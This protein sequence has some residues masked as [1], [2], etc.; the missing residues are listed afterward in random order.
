V[1]DDRQ[2]REVARRLVDVPGV[3]GVVLGG[4]RARG[5]HA[6]DSDVD[7]GLYYRPPLDV[8]AL[9]RHARELAGP[10]ARL[11]QPGAWGPWVDGGGW[12]RIADTPVDWIY[13][14]IDRVQLSWAAA[15]EGRY[16]FH[17]Q[18][19][20]PLGVPD[21]AYA[22]ELA[23]GVVLADPFGELSALQAA[24]RHYPPRLGHALVAGLAEATFTVEIARKAIAR[25]D[26][27]YVAGCLFRAVELCA[28]ALHGHERRWLIN[29]KGA[30]AAA[31]RLPGAPAGFADRAHGLLASLGTRPR[32]LERAVEAAARLI[33]DTTAAC[34]VPA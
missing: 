8:A 11:T 16:S 22:G 31:G 5:E 19:G 2:L 28:Y 12:L 32:E 25:A 24:T 15:Q 20:H 21:F 18:V 1:I 34:Q 3:L 10:T 29:E 17:A 30:V 4:S 23:L 6:P 7:L 13:R 33:A 27:A 26:S 9:E 14:D